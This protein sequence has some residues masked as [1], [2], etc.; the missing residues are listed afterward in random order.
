M[1]TFP[2]HSPGPDLERARTWH[3]YALPRRRPVTTIGDEAAVAVT[4]D[5]PETHRPL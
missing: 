4:T 2:D 1:V 3:A 5:E